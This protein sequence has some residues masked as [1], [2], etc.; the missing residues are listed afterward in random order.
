MA[1]SQYYNLPNPFGRTSDDIGFETA[2]LT[3]NTKDTVRSNIG[4]T[5]I[6]NEIS[7]ITRQVVASLFGN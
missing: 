4:G 6:I 2:D 7:I 5:F 1:T 3:L